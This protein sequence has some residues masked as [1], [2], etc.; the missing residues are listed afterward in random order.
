M[1]KRS[2]WTLITSFLFLLLAFFVFVDTYG[3]FELN[4]EVPVAGNLAKWQILVNSQDIMGETKTFLIP[5]VNWETSPDV[6]PGKAA[7]GLSASFDIIIDPSTTEVAIEYEL[8]LDFIEI[9]NEKVYLTGVKNKSGVTILPNE[10]DK[11]VGQI[12][13][14]AVL[15]NETETLTVSFIWENDEDNND[16]DSSF[17]GVK[18]AFLNI[19]ITLKL[20]QYLG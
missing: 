2:N 17:V 4:T 8:G 11:Y 16:M 13:L 3:L 9:T 7:P 1:N 10:D 20:S 6:L 12:L 15:N 14:P 5:T 18:D 19:P